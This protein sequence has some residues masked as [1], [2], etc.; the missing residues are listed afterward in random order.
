MI[1]AHNALLVYKNNLKSLIDGGSINATYEESDT[2]ISFYINDIDNGTKQILTL[3]LSDHDPNLDNYISNGNAVHMPWDTKNLSV[4]LYVP[5]LLPN[6]SVRRNRASTKVRIPFKLRKI[7]RPFKV[8][9]FEYQPM[10]LDQ[11]DV[12]AIY[13]ALLQYVQGNGFTD[14]LA[15]TPKEAKQKEVESKLVYLPRDVCDAEYNFYRRQGLGDGVI[16]RGKVITEKSRIRN[17]N[18]KISR[19]INEEIMKIISKC[20][21]LK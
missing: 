20:K 14:P 9:I 16:K 3:R 2:T 6:G 8:K 13:D 17:L 18:E 11:S 1:D 10:L 7:A 19:I 5:Q 15:G 12:P 4:E 21:R